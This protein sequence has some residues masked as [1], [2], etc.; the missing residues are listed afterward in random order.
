DF[1]G[2]FTS[3][4]IPGLPAGEYTATIFV[5]DCGFTVDFTIEEINPA[6]S[7]TI[8]VQGLTCPDDVAVVTVVPSVLGIDYEYN[9]V[10]ITNPAFVDDSLFVGLTP[11][12]YQVIT[13]IKASQCTET[14]DFNL[15]PFGLDFN[16]LAADVQ[17]LTC[18]RSFDGSF[19]IEVSDGLP[20]QDY[21]FQ[22]NEEGWQADSLFSGLEAGEY[23]VGVR[24]TGAN[25][26][27]EVTVSLQQPDPNAYNPILNNATCGEDNGQ[28]IFSSPRGGTPPY[29]YS[30]DGGEN[31][32]TNSVFIG[33]P[34]GDYQAVLRD[35]N[36]CEVGED[37]SIIDEDTPPQI[38]SLVN[39]TCFMPGS[40]RLT[41][42]VGAESYVLLNNE[43]TFLAESNDP[44][45]NDLAPGD[46]VIEVAGTCDFRVR[47]SLVGDFSAFEEVNISAVPD[48]GEGTGR[49][50]ITT[51]AAAFED[52]EFRLL[53]TP[54]LVP[55]F[56]GL[57]AGDYTVIGTTTQGCEETFRI[58]V[59]EFAE[60][61]RVS[62]LL[63]STPSCTSVRAGSFAIQY[64]GPAN[65]DY[66]FSLD[67]QVY[68]TDSIFTGLPSGTYTYFVRLD[69]LEC[70]YQGEIEVPFVN[71]LEVIA[72]VTDIFCGEDAGAVELI[73][74]NGL[75]PLR[76]S[77][78]TGR[79]FQLTG[80]FAG[81]VAGDYAA[82]VRDG[83]S[84]TDTVRFTIRD[85]REELVVAVESNPPTCA[86]DQDGRAAIV[87]NSGTGPFTFSWPDGR[88]DSVRNDLPVGTYTVSVTSAF[89]CTNT[90][91]F[92]LTQTPLV[93][94][95]DVF[96]TGCSDSGRI[97][98][99]VSGGTGRYTFAWNNDAVSPTIENLAEGSYTVTV[100][101]TGGCSETATYTVNRLEPLYVPFG[102]R[103]F[104][105]S[106]RALL[107]PD[108]PVQAISWSTPD[109]LLLGMSDTLVVSETLTVEVRG[110]D[111]LSCPFA[112]TIEVREAN[113]VLVANF[114][115]ADQAI[116]GDTVVLVENSSF[117]PDD[118]DWEFTGPAPVVP[119]RDS[120]NQYWFR[121]DSVGVYTATLIATAGD[122]QDFLTKTITIVQDS[123]ELMP[124]APLFNEVTN[125]VIS[126]NP[127]PGPFQAE[128]SLSAARSVR[129]RVYNGNG[130]LVD[131]EN[132]P[133]ALNH[134]IRLSPRIE[135]PGAYVVVL[136]TGTQVL[137]R[138][139]IVQQ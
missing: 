30:I 101:D 119:V 135:V 68:A 14:L 96:D 27:R 63:L 131:Q 99:D 103:V 127:T 25:C 138:T 38:E 74:S 6:F 69:S 7:T 73:T 13:R 42:V 100:T 107:I 53:E 49:L 92:E 75:E 34:T 80:D 134:R 50:V 57:D 120:L 54:E 110:R 104:C 128:V 109:G 46:Y 35:A 31:F 114:L 85:G 1:F 48:C 10:G 117:T 59:P 65:L 125:F 60:E 62:A 81:L 88:Q 32:S 5:F 121:F 79:T 108:F 18:F 41:E 23:S 4:T 112:E 82:V 139:L 47:F 40:I 78:D 106:S 55:P 22:L 123:T 61:I 118:L 89:Q 105:R 98:L 37:F 132:S 83:G 19:R 33:L 122:C 16:P 43:G 77:L 51:G 87:V 52:F 124:D 126:P 29:R 28:F 93:V 24:L 136:T 9:L 137:Y 130:V 26:F 45:F 12:V 15:S 129:I 66:Q 58:V 36:G 116:A 72:T 94:R 133:V 8:E 76:Y 3:S 39:P 90:I 97:A 20:G 64:D 44:A 56:T 111:S 70:I 67:D 91:T 113:D 71:N 115:V 86:D 84:C 2:T 21:E 95:A 11:G 17:D 102:D